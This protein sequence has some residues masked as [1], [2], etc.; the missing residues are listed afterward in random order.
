MKILLL[1]LISS[2]SLSLAAQNVNITFQGANKNRNY[3]VV[4]DGV[5]YYS[6]NSI[7]T[8]NAK[9]MIDVPNLVAGAHSLEV[10]RIKN[11]NVYTNGSTNNEV[12]G[13]AVYN[14]T[15]Q[16]R[17]GYDMN[18]TVRGNGMVSFTEKRSKNQSTVTNAVPMSSSAF[19]KLL[20]SVRNKRYQSDKT[21][22]IS[23]A[24]NTAGNYFTTSQVRELLLLV[25]T[26]KRRLDLAK[27]SYKKLTDPANFSYV[28]DVLE[29]ETAKDALDNYVVAQGGYASTSTQ[30]NAAY[31]TP[32]A[33][34]SFN[35]L[36]QKV[37]NYTYQ[38][39]R[40]SEIRNSLNSSYN[41]F[42]TFQVKQLLALVSSESERLTLAK[43]AFAHVTDRIN[44]NQLVD[45][46]YNQY[47]RDELNNFI[48][49]NG[50]VANTE[51]YKA[52]MTDASFTKIYNKAR[53][54]FFQKNTLNEI[55]DAFNNNSNSFSTEQVKQLLTLA[56]TEPDKLALA[57]LAYPRVVDTVNFSQLLDL[58]SIQSNRTELDMFIKAQAY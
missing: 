48:L 14:K 9:K 28:Y 17:P 54:H 22:L 38:D 23:N 39:D 19:N 50:G 43:S 29:T 33:D 13:N 40:L 32:M 44:Y 2:L 58:F 7:S 5:S 18:I 41:Y 25:T 52:P 3:Q 8:N 15:F 4:I 45:L 20:I 56:R 6:A 30:S 21:T 27:T 55:R 51:N 1:F 31:G 35:Q 57:K 37:R 12:N 34:A 16:L 46:F 42:S 24:L 10:Y 53:S 26:E 49:S 11:N 47:S 36:L